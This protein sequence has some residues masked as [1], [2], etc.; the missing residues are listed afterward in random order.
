MQVPFGNDGAMNN[1][2]K[3]GQ[4]QHADLEIEKEKQEHHFENQNFLN[5]QCACEQEILQGGLLHT[6][7]FE[8]EKLQEME[9]HKSIEQA[10]FFRIDQLT[11]CK[12]EMLGIIDYVG[13]RLQ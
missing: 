5:G 9:N 11:K 4:F 1:F 13:I 12:K 10:T 2:D 3:V 6:C 8:A 7:L